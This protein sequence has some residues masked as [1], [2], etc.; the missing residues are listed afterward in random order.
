MMMKKILL[1]FILQLLF[2]SCSIDNAPNPSYRT[3]VMP[4]ESV[5]IPEHFVYGESYEIQVTYNR[6]S[7]CY[8]FFD[9]IYDINENVRTVV[10]VN[11]IYDNASCVQGTES[12]AANFEFP[13]N[14]TETYV[15]KFYQGEDENGVDQYYLVEVPVVYGRSGS[16][17]SQIK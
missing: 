7:S 6:P 9:F 10:V 5:E 16:S 17:N 13:V 4:I 14:D 8:Q 15:F 12:V 3:E 1:C 11:I 2:S